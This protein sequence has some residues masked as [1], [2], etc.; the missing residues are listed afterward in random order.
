MVLE[1]TKEDNWYIKGA[2]FGKVNGLPSSRILNLFD[3]MLDAWKLLT[4]F[5]TEESHKRQKNIK[6]SRA[7]QCA[8]CDTK[9]QRY[10]QAC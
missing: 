3:I 9:T 2:K 4:G 7:A 10:A 1:L 5:T 6:E 8:L